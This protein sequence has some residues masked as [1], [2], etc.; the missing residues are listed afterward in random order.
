LVKR[1]WRMALTLGRIG[2]KPP[3]VGRDWL[4]PSFR[5]TSSGGWSR[6]VGPWEPRW[7]REEDIPD[8]VYFGAMEALS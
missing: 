3:I 5:R 6:T 7:K 1:G 4:E 2:R 8:T